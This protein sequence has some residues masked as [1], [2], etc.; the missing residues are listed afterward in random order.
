MHLYALE[1]SVATKMPSV[2]SPFAILINIFFFV[3]SFALSIDSKAFFDGKM[4]ALEICQGADSK[5][6]RHVSYLR[7][8]VF[9]FHLM[10]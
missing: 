1:P 7:T 6:Q 9:T 3:L 10:N 5:N 8:A 4:C 2:H